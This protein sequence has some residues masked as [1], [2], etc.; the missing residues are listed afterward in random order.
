MDDPIGRVK[1]VFV[2]AYHRVRLMRL[3]HVRQH[4]RSRPRQLELPFGP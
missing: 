3:E 1:D 2:H 4:W